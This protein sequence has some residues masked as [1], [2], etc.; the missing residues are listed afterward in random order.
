MMKL[1]RQTPNLPFVKH[2]RWLVGISILFMTASVFFI[3][4]RGL[5][6]GTDFLGGV[7]L[8]YQ[9]PR[10][11]SEGEIRDLL[12]NLD[13]GDLQVIRFGKAEEKRIVIKV[14][15]TTDEIA[16]VSQKIT[17][18]LAKAYGE[19]GL[20]LEKEETVGSK[21]GEE[22]RRKGILAVLF[23]LVCMLI[24]VG[25]RFDFYFAPGAILALFHDVLVVLGVFALLQLEFNLT[26]LAA[27]LTIVG[28]SINDTIVIFD[29]IREHARLISPST[30][31]EVVNK[32]VNETLTR[33]IN[34]TLTVFMT[35]VVL[36]LFG[37][38]TIKDFSFALLV[39]VISGTYSTLSIATACYLW[40]YHTAPQVAT[41]M[42]WL[43]RKK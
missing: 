16:S 37:G 33:T 35:V 24:Y 36:Y 11:V 20:I 34:T 7:N 41:R 1:F 17:P 29:R 31:E 8:L 38:A 3:S 10:P 40:M 13:L 15:K 32:S 25:F 19:G 23:S 28:Y 42:E 26:I 14:S 30:V 18:E 39:G 22:L 2:R 27:C 9:F 6:Y 4:T 21:V 43:F 12:K 5:N